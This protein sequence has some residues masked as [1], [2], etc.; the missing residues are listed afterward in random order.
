MA[1]STLFDLTGKH[2]DIRDPVDLI[3]E[4]FHTHR[5]PPSASPEK[6]PAHHPAH[7]MFLAEIHVISCVLNVDQLFDH[8]IT[9]LLH[10]RT[11]R[12]HHIKV[13]L[14]CSQ[15]IDTGNTG[16]HNHIF[17]SH[18]CCCR[19]KPQ[20]INLIVQRRILRNVGV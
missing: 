5:P 9:V 1:F 3:P 14:R 13:I 11:E 8:L 2:I 17:R 15:T 20:L 6:S 16:N 10:S 19:G 18:Q 12:N 4:K 7:G